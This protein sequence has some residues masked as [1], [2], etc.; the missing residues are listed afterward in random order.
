MGFS[1]KYTQTENAENSKPKSNQKTEPSSTKTTAAET[2]KQ[3]AESQ[4]MI[5]SPLM[6]IKAFIK[7]LSS[8]FYDGRV[9]LN[10]D[11]SSK[12]TLK[13]MLLNPDACFEEIVKQARCIILAGG[14]MKPVSCF[15]MRSL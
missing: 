1:E 8:P 2:Q 11:Q 14:T 5:K 13:F 12:S 10:I 6:L 15:E 9:L 3:P 4:F 7:V